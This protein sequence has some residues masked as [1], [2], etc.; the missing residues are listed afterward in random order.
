MPKIK[1][2]GFATFIF[3]D[4][5][6]VTINETGRLILR[7]EKEICI[8][9]QT[10]GKVYLLGKGGELIRSHPLFAG[11]NKIDFGALELGSY[12]LRIENKNNF[13]VCS[14]EIA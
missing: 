13:S 5:A 7:E 10:A 14:F 3:I 6:I 11:E 1:W 2:V 9:S 4:M 8:S 12:V